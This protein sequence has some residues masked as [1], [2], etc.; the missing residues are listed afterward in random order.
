MKLIDIG[1]NLSDDMFQGT[2]N[3]KK[4]H[5]S[6]IDDVLARARDANLE[7]L[8]I[9]GTSI[10]DIEFSLNYLKELKESPLSLQ[11]TIGIHPTRCNEFIQ[12]ENLL[13]RLSSLIEQNKQYVCAVGECGL[14]YDRTKFCDKDVQKQY[15][16]LQFQLA[17]KFDLPMFL[18]HRAASED[19]L[20]IMKEH[21]NDFKTA[22]VHSYDD[23]WE[24]ADELLKLKPDGIFIG[25]NGCSMKTEENLNVI[26][27]LPLESILI[28]TDA[29]WCDIRPSHASY[30]HL[31]KQSL[32][33][34]KSQKR[35]DRFQKGFQVKSRNEPSNI[36]FVLD[37]VSSLK[38]L[39]RDQVADQLYKNTKRWLNKLL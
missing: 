1:V 8:I 6:D 11:M 32:D 18:H 33:T 4:Y 30:K 5:E 28:E 9:T 38:K 29:P 12:H 13:D 7:Q 35:R 14:D 36:H 24:L 31:T 17:K 25:L 10:E 19:F 27:K 16:A 2:Y 34:I 21:V 20:Q 23:S 26:E 37:V 22:V 15:F 3:D 39:P